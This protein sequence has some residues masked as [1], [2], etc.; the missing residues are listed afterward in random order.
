MSHEDTLNRI[1]DE[2]HRR[3]FSDGGIEIVMEI[4][5]TELSGESDRNPDNLIMA[6]SGVK[7]AN[8]RD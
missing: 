6:E 7:P 1:E 3:Q 8:W 4:I 2:L 5:E